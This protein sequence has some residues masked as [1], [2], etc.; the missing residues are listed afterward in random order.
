MDDMV[1][2]IAKRDERARIL[3]ILKDY[4]ELG[5][6]DFRKQYHTTREEETRNMVGAYLALVIE[7]PAK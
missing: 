1:I 3:A 5:Y 2:A 6:M 4:D 7:R